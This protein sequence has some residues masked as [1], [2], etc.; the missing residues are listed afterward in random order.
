MRTQLS[1]SCYMHTHSTVAELSVLRN[2]LESLFY[3]SRDVVAYIS[4]RVHCA[5]EYTT[6]PA[7]TIVHDVTDLVADLV[8]YIR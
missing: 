3:D 4:H 6:I 8:R 7:V 1:A 5:D 2:S